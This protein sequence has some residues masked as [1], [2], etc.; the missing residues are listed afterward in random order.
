VSRAAPRVNEAFRLGFKKVLAPRSNLDLPDGK[1]GV[2]IVGVAS[3][4]ELASL[5]FE[6]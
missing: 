4:G 1:A 5:L 6:W 3:I 2:E